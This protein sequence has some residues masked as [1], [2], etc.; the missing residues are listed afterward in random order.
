M[1]IIVVNCLIIFGILLCSFG[2]TQAVGFSYDQ[3]SYADQRDSGNRIDYHQYMQQ[4]TA[5]YLSTTFKKN[6][7]KGHSI[8]S[9]RNRPHVSPF[10]TPN[11]TPASPVPEP[12]TGLM[13]AIG[14]A[15]LLWQARRKYSR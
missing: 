10:V 11:S 14:L 13:L 5:D 15:G 2:Q 8:I 1:K 9:W 12:A 4:E 3:F 7:P 6:E